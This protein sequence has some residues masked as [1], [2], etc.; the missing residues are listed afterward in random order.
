MGLL[1][2]TGVNNFVLESSRT[3][4]VIDIET[5]SN[6]GRAGRYMFRTDLRRIVALTVAQSVQGS[7]LYIVHTSLQSNIW[8]L[9]KPIIP[10]PGGG[11]KLLIDF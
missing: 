11:C 7:G 3:P 8:I 5:E 6:S 4:G 9:A 10:M 2:G 1:S